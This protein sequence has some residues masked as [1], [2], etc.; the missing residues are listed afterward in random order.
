M[1]I[2]ICINKK[3]HRVIGFKTIVNI[4][5]EKYSIYN[6][7]MLIISIIMDKY[8]DARHVWKFHNNNGTNVSGV[9]LFGYKIM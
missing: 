4:I 2:S 1:S 7:M 5:G 8:F 6:L 3:I 9:S